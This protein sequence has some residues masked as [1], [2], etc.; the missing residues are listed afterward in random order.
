M[1]PMGAGLGFA[2]SGRSY[3]VISRA[4]ERGGKR[5]CRRPK[6]DPLFARCREH[7]LL[8]R[9]RSIESIAAAILQ[10]DVRFWFLA[11]VSRNLWFSELGNGKCGER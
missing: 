1:G 3:G 7:T 6:T 8:K 9:L 5:R 10:L 4:S 11:S 2:F